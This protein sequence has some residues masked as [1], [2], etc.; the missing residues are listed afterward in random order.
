MEARSQRETRDG[1][2]LR[3]SGR[4]RERS[5]GNRRDDLGH[6]VAVEHE[7]T[8]I[9]D[10]AVVLGRRAREQR[11]LVRAEPDLSKWSASGQP[12]GQR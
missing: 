9:A 11:R 10:D 6:G 7:Q 12:G 4:E 5:H 1:G 8:A 3:R 2:W